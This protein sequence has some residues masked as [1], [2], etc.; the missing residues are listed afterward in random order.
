MQSNHVK[1]RLEA[2]TPKTARVMQCSGMFDIP[3]DQKLTLEWDHHLPLDEKPWQV[4]LIVGPSGAGKSVL[5][6]KLWPNQVQERYQW[7][8]RKSLLDNFPHE[9]STT[10]ITSMFNSVGL[11]SVPSWLRPYNT[12]SNGEKF[13]ADMARA[14]LTND[15]L[16]VI[17]EFTSVVDRQVA[18]VAS[19][20]VQKAV[21]RTQKQFVAVTCHYDVEDW[22]QPDWLYDVATQKFV[23][24]CVQPR[25]K[26]TLEIHES[27]T[28]EW[29][30]FAHH[31]Y[32]SATI[33]PSAKCYTATINGKPVAFTSYIHFMHPKTKNIKM[34]HRLVVLPDYQGLGIA[35]ILAEWLGQHLWE[36][37]YRYRFVIGH[38][39]IIRLCSKSPRWRETHAKAKKVGTSKKSI[40]KKNNLSSRRLTMRSFEYTPPKKKKTT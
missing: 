33:L 23:W 17:D 26:L 32:L 13:R 37:G 3:L 20:C 10:D 1:I 14:L 6:N 38:P 31:H 18:K 22:L 9:I 30:T 8:A 40:N 35:S 15:E 27:S 12:L 39:A 5:A 34:A 21:R 25:P 2:D 4:G 7:D 16:T 29:K 28:K 11:G 24:R 19:H 36:Q